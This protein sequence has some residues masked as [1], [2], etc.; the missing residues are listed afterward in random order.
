MSKFSDLSD[1]TLKL[2]MDQV[3]EQFEDE[4]LDVESVGDYVQNGNIVDDICKYVGVDDLSFEDLSYLCGLFIDNVDTEPPLKRP[5]LKRFKIT[6]KEDYVQYGTRYYQQV[7]GSY[8]LLDSNDLYSMRSE[9]IYEYWDGTVVENDVYDE[10]TN[11]D[12]ITDID[13]ID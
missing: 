13:V 10:E 1:R 2:I 3:K 11:D 4:G 7:V 9:G 6:H 8:A 5:R 12:E